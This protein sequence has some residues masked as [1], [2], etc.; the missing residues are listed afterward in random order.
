M[1]SGRPS[2]RLRSATASRS[3]PSALLLAADSGVRKA[4]Y[5]LALMLYA[6]IGVEHDKEGA[7]AYFRMAADQGVR[8]AHMSDAAMKEGDGVYK[9]DVDTARYFK[10][11][12][13]QDI[14]KASRP[15]TSPPRTSSSRM[16]G[17][18]SVSSQRTFGDLFGFMNFGLRWA[19]SL[20]WFS[21]QVAKE[22]R[23]LKNMFYWTV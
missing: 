10:L 23:I 18:N 19:S 1:A 3:A 11:A 15:W 2:S 14:E 20:E 17:E 13:D 9:N 8:E 6:G 16:N 12:A 5:N 22:L 4:Q 21:S 7:A